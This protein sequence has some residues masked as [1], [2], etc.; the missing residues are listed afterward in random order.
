MDK[1]FKLIDLVRNMSKSKL[2]IKNLF[3][4]F[5]NKGRSFISAVEKGM[6]KQ[7]LLDKHGHVLGLNLSLIH[8]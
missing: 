5:G 6:S 8:I 2:K 3:K 1:D 7:E 4:I